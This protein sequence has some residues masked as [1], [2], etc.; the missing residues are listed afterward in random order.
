MKV[1][2]FTFIRNAI[3]YEYPIV[4]AIHSILPLCDQVI[5][6]VGNS[7]DGTL[8]LIKSIDPSKIIINETV[9]DDSLREGGRVLALET[10]KSYQL[11]PDDTDWAFYIQGDEVLHESNHDN[12]KKA[13][14]K[15][16]DD[17]LVEGLLFK[18]RHF[19]GSYD[20]VGDSLRWYRREIR[21]VKYNPDV[22]SYKDAQ[23]F[24]KKPNEKLNV[25]LID[26]YVHHYGWVKAP[27]A[28]QR[29]QQ[30][31]HKLWH[32]DE[33]LD[34]NVGKA[35]EFDYSG[36]DSLE[37]YKGTHPLVMQEFLENNNWKFDYDLSKNKLRLKDKIKKTIERIT[38]YRLGEYRNYK[39]LR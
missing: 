20:Y 22:F 4:E 11:I 31:F 6:S 33:W 27:D 26:A 24:R 35:E 10:D 36:I 15:Y 16:K 34:N 23:G 13:M 14:E 1:V 9:W 3:K 2:G 30:A 25:K 5:V 32:D 38:G 12:I 21:L 19:Y 18:Y 37:L 28:M 7:E 29:K 17:A 39:L 8:E